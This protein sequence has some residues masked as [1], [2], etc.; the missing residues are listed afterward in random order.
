MNIYPDKIS[1]EEQ[2]EELLSRPGDKVTE[3]FSRLDGDIM[4]LGIGGKIG[5]S[6][7]YMAK[8]ACDK[9]RVKK[10]IIGVSLF[11]SEEQRQKI[12]KSMV[13]RLFMG[14]CWIWIS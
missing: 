6:L 3:M 1:N 14:I 10:K 9:A 5:P 8:R 11:E 7:A 13:L 4:F 2:L 12:Q